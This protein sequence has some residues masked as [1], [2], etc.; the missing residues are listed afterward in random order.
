MHRNIEGGFDSVTGF[1]NVL[2]TEIFCADLND[3]WDKTGVCFL[4]SRYDILFLERRSRTRLHRCAACYTA[5]EENDMVINGNYMFLGANIERNQQHFVHSGDGRG[6]DDGTKT[7]VK[8]NA[9]AAMANAGYTVVD[10]G[11]AKL[12]ISPESYDCFFSEEGQEKIR[13]SGDDLWT[14]HLEQQKKIAEGRDQD[15]VFW[16]DTGNQWKIFSQYLYENG[17]YDGMTDEEVDGMEETLAR[18]T[19]GMDAVSRWQYNTGMCFSNYTSGDRVMRNEE[20]L[21]ELESST[22]ALRY[23]AE[24]YVSSDKQEA[25]GKLIDL[26]HA[27]NEEITRDYEHPFEGVERGIRDVQSGMYG[28]S[29]L[30]TEKIGRK[31]SEDHKFVVMRARI[32]KTQE[33][34]DRFRADVA[35]MFQNYVKNT[36][37]GNSFW[38]QLKEMYAGYATDGSQDE[39]F[40]DYTLNEAADTFDRMQKYWNRLLG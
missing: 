36:A 27:H 6:M 13:R 9:D 40:R 24:K 31:V 5:Q 28:D 12:S 22:E 18:I 16:T 25:F 35:Q 14:M 37:G 20:A 19:A 39:D 17:M 30:Y 7:V 11:N 8:Q 4:V 2:T 33:Q 29:A 3:L 10:A 15:D 32:L 38:E 1:S 34:K 26:Y 21:M 23:F